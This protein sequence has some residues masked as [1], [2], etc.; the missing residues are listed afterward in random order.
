M[1]SKPAGPGTG[2]QAAWGAPAGGWVPA[3][4]KEAR[5]AVFGYLSAI[6]TGPLVP[7]AVYAVVRRRS[8][9]LRAHAAMALNLSVTWLL[10]TV[11]C[12]ILC[13]LLMLDTLTV[14]LVVAGAIASFF[15]WMLIGHLI[16]GSKAASR[17]ERY[18]VPGWL[19]ARLAKA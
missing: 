16:R 2:P 15:W 13:G 10:Y 19:C 1:T 7:L 17:G 18:T 3:S 8:W 9:Y 11:C 14:A 5:A 4:D 12:A 6:V